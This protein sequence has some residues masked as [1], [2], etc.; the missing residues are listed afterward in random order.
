MI[1]QGAK[2]VE[3]AQDILEELQPSVP[4][5]KASKVAKATTASNRAAPSGTSLA[6]EL[7]AARRT[8]AETNDP[9]LQAMAFEPVNHDLLALRCGLDSAALSARML[10]LELAGQVELLPGGAYQR[11]F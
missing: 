5:I 2:L 7:P 11:L 3:S 9:I 6:L 1:K 10:D 4:V 8:D